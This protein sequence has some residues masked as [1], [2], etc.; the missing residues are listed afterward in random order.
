MT[1][2]G[3]SKV[4]PLVTEG[5]SEIL[6]QFVDMQ[7]LQERANQVIS[8]ATGAEAGFVSACAASGITLAVAACMT[9]VNL[10]KV[11]KL[12]N[13]EGMKNEV[14]IQKGHSIYF[15]TSIDQMI[16]LSG[17]KVIEIGNVNRCT[18]YQLKANLNE[19]TAA[20]MY[21]ISHHTIRYGQIPLNRFVDEAHRFEIPVI[22]DAAAQYDLKDIIAKGV[23]IVVCSGHKYLNAP[24]S[25][26]LCGK[27]DLIRACYLQELGI[28]RAM[29]VGKEGIVG[30]M[31]A[32][33]NRE[34]LDQKKIQDS[35]NYRADYLLEKL[36]R[37]EN[38][39]VTL[40]DDPTGNPVKRVKVEID[41]SRTG[42]T[43]F[44]LSQELENCDPIIKVRAH[45]TEEGYF[46][47]DPRT[48]ENEQL[49]IVVERILQI[50]NQPDTEKTKLKEKYKGM[51][52]ATFPA[53]KKLEWLKH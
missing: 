32:L 13:T 11:E 31:I 36:K 51:I 16:R 22:V 20:A 1:S 9:G 28:G 47:L 43:A 44:I 49:D 2:L 15:E 19:R 29:K 27:K 21:I 37:I 7:E 35:W 26:I 4:D 10:E 3:A 6:S 53:D 18:P 41:P 5:I 30:V 39:T 40:E 24:T 52:F 14:I 38:L 8:E 12:P 34:N 42:L 48:L 23:D 46:L 50:L 17:A 25:G 33:E 45:H